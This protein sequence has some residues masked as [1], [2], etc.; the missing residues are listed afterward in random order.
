[1]G[2]LDL[3]ITD[4]Q[5]SNAVAGT[6]TAAALGGTY[7]PIVGGINYV[8]S[9]ASPALRPWF[10]AL[11]NNDI[12]KASIMVIGDSIT[13]GVGST[14][15]TNLYDRGYVPRLK[16]RIRNR[17]GAANGMGYIPATWANDAS[18]PFAN[19][20]GTISRASNNYG[21][22]GRSII[23]NA[24]ANVSVTGISG[25]SFDVMVFS[26]GSTDPVTVKIDGVA[27][28]SPVVTSGASLDAKVVN[29]FTLAA[30]TH[31]IDISCA[32]GTTGVYFEGIY[33]YNGDEDKGIRII[34]CGHSGWTT[35]DHLSGQLG[36]V[37]GNLQS[38]AAQ[39][40]PDLCII[41]LGTN[42]A[43]QGLT[44]ATYKANLQ[45]IITRVRA[46]VA[47]SSN[48]S[49]L[50]VGLYQRD[51]VILAT[52]WQQYLDAAASV[53]STD[54]G[55]P[56]GASGVTFLDLSKRIY[57]FNTSN[58]SGFL[59]TDKVHPTDKGHGYIADVIVQAIS[60]R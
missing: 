39:I 13:E 3:P 2:I 34:E 15:T 49:F 32:T 57:D 42:D 10:A 56:A 23:L 33:V 44:P 11:A 4:D 14:V 54:T 40:A 55:G 50:L 51:D 24:G 9:A 43:N 48:V 12:T 52:P 26:G 31:T 5:L 58:V 16:T 7:A 38:Q 37:G 47:T 19:G 41:S 25:T 6:K 59:T 18:R 29:R 30:G 1:M 60:P 28:G 8:S 17:F 36:I 22:G 35:A 46:G 27:Q 45:T 21:P 20:T 53:A